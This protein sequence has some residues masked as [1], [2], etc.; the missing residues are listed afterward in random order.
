MIGAGSEDVTALPFDRRTVPFGTFKTLTT[1]SGSGFSRLGSSA[2]TGVPMN[3]G[4]GNSGTISS[5]SP[6]GAAASAGAAA[7]AAAGA[8]ALVEEAAVSGALPQDERERATARLLPRMR[9]WVVF[10]MFWG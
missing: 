4:F 2:G 3:M 10:F 1:L 7:V 9:F 8:G 5:M 6:A